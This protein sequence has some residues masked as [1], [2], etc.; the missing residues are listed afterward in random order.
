M[1]DAARP[2]FETKSRLTEL[3]AKHAHTPGKVQGAIDGVEFYRAEEPTECRPVVYRP[4][5]IIVAQGSKCGL[6]GDQQYEYNAYNYLVLSV[7]LP[8][9]AQVKEASRETPFLSMCISVD[10][11]MLG[12]LLID[13]DE[14]AEG[15]DDEGYGA[16][17]VAMEQAIHAAPLTDHIA[18]AA[19]RLI[20]AMDHETERKVLARQIVREI[21]YRVLV[22]ERGACLRAAARRGGKFHQL[23]EVLR[24]LHTEYNHAFSVHDM[25]SIA[26]MS[27]TA[28]HANFKAITSMTPLQYLKNIRLHQARNMMIRD[29]LNASTAA[30]RVGYASPFQFSREYKRLFGAPPSR[31]IRDVMPEHAF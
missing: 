9:V 25:A 14:D 17:S 30:F 10:P 12:D 15:L 27:A 20:E 7:P 29:G 3:I 4:C 19:V 26:G 31:E 21:I 13:L 8:L 24:T 6:L 2:D 5:I 28:F 22:G 18:G 1:L 23:A 16:S 11:V